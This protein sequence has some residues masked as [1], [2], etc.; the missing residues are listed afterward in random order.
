MT[1]G[2]DHAHMNFREW[3]AREC[4]KIHWPNDKPEE[5]DTLSDYGKQHWFDWA[6]KLIAAFHSADPESGV[7]VV[8]AEPEVASTTSEGLWCVCAEVPG[9]GQAIV[10]WEGGKG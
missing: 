9:P 2:S 7:Q 10:I 5:F 6:D 3:L 8:E 1:T 4:R